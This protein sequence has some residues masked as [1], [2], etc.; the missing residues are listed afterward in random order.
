MGDKQKALAD[1]DEAAKLKPNLPG[2][3]RARAVFLMEDD[4]LDEAVGLLE[5]LAKRDPK[6]TLTLLQL[7]ISYTARKNWA[8]AI[9]TDRAILALD[10]LE[11]RALRG[12]GDAMLNTGRQAEAVAYYEK[13]I[14][15]ERSDEG[16]LN[17]LAWARHLAGRETPQRPPSDS[18]CHSGLQTYR[19]QSPPRAEH[20]GRRLRR[21]RR[22]RQCRPLVEQSR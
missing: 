5:Q 13:A 17:N 18:T 12:L 11:W 19:V 4:R 10:P 3:L 7:S 21:D 9:E 2:I 6:D 14:K 16:L 8:K 22:F 15:I 1:L 20:L